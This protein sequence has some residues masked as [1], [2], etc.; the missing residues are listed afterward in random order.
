MCGQAQAACDYRLSTLLR[1]IGSPCLFSRTDGHPEGRAL[2]YKSKCSEPLGQGAALPIGP[3][4]DIAASGASHKL[5]S[6]RLHINVA[7]RADVV[8]NFRDVAQ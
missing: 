1:S 3:C 4:G 8:A 5:E 2:Y 7:L 6:L